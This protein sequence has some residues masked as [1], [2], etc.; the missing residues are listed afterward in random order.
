VY[1][2]AVGLAALLQAP[3]L[4]VAVSII[5]VFH[6][7]FL[8]EL[9]PAVHCVFEYTNKVVCITVTNNTA[10]KYIIPSGSD[11]YLKQI[12]SYTV[13]P[14]SVR[15]VRTLFYIYIFCPAMP[16]VCELWR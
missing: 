6:D 1:S 3:R 14:G 7:H 2:C 15:T 11:T 12:R 5:C 10:E 4:H 9:T 16:S 13:C 8:S